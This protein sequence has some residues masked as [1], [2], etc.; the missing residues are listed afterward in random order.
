MVDIWARTHVAGAQV[1]VKVYTLAGE[2]VAKLDF[3]SADR[4]TW[5]ITNAGGERLA[6]GVYLVVVVANDPVS[7]QSERQILKLAV[8][9]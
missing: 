5:N 2:L 1:R 8:V 3:G 9:R 4:L 7:G 6:S